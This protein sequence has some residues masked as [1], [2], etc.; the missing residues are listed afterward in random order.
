[1][2]LEQ[3]NIQEIQDILAKDKYFIHAKDD[4]ENTLLHHAIF[5]ESLEDAKFLIEH[6]ACPLVYNS[7]IMNPF[8]LACIL[9]NSDI[10]DFLLFTC[11]DAISPLDQCFMLAT[12]TSKGCYNTTKCLL[13]NGFD[14]NLYYRDDPIIYWAVQS[15]SVSIMELLNNFGADL[16]AYNEYGDS[17]LY[18]AAGDEDAIEIVRFLLA[19]G[20][21]VD[22]NSKCSCTPL[23]LSCAYGNNDIAEVLLLH[24]A[25]IEAQ[26]SEGLTPLL[27]A[28]RYGRIDTIRLL[29]KYG[30]NKAAVDKKKRDMNYY[31][32][33]LRKKTREEM[34]TML[35]NYGKW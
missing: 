28:L 15:N 27:N 20:A 13:V 33:K 8:S 21:L 6:G 11:K 25:E 17:A 35:S 31:I 10:L 24:G 1:M 30:A 22:G 18:L 5:R 14:C 26:D 16:N 34:I 23:T 4:E 9:D 32:G 19:H 12:A 2:Q 3:L 29:L 7:H